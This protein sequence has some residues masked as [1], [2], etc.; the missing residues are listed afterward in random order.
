MKNAK[1]RTVYVAGSHK[2]FFSKKYP[3]K[4]VNDVIKIDPNYINWCINNLKHLR[5]DDGVKR[6]VNKAIQI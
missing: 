4:S 6:L 3:D 5:F 1:T 2:C